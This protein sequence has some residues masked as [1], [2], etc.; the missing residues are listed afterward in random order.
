MLFFT[1]PYGAGDLAP[2]T[3]LGGYSFGKDWQEKESDTDQGY[4]V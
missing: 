4:E 3:P 2:V 1:L